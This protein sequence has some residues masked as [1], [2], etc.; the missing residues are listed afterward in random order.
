MRHLRER[1]YASV[2]T[3]RRPGEHW[4]HATTSRPLP[5]WISDHN[6]LQRVHTVTDDQPYNHAGPGVDRSMTC[7]RCRGFAD[8]V[9]ASPRTVPRIMAGP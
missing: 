4:V 7:R 3:M 9:S 5:G 8:Y 6:H 1:L 2:C